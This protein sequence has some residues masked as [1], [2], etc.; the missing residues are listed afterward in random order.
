MKDNHVHDVQDIRRFF[1][2]PGTAPAQP[3][4]G[5]LDLCSCSGYHEPANMTVDAACRRLT[6]CGEE[7]KAG[8]VAWACILVACIGQE[9]V[10]SE[11]DVV[12]LQVQASKVAAAPAP[13]APAEAKAPKRSKY[14][15][16]QEGSQK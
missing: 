2:K 10:G 4:A 16:S 6:G 15:S 13:A 1:A 9:D 14:F 11:P 3:A 5:A 12:I 7:A 8:G